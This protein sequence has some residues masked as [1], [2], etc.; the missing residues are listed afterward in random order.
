MASNVANLNQCFQG[1]IQ[2]V[3]AR[4]DLYQGLAKINQEI[5]NLAS[6]FNARQPSLQIFSHFPLLSNGLNKFFNTHPGFRQFYNSKVLDFPINSI[7]TPA[8]QLPTLILKAN[9]AVG[10]SE[11][12]YELSPSR[13]LLLGRDLQHQKDSSVLHIPLPLYKKVSG[14]HAEIQ[15]VSNVGSATQSWQL[16][17]LNS[18]NG[19]YI[20]GQKIKGCQVLTFGDRITLSYPNASEK[21]PEFVFEGQI[22]SSD[23]NA[24][25]S[26]QVDAD[27]VFLVIHP[28]QGLSVSEKQLIKQI[29]KTSV[30]GFVI[31][32]D[33]SGTKSQDSPSIK[34]NLDSIRSWIQNQY[35]QLAASLEL[36]ELSLYP[37]YPDTPSAQLTPAIEQQFVQFAA[38]FIDLAKNQG[39]ELIANRIN[40]QLLVQIQKIDQIL[41]S[42]EEALKH[43]MQRTEA[44]LNGR[45]L[46]SWR[47]HYNQ[48][49]KQIDEAR[50]DFF[51]EARTQFFRARDEFSMDFIPSSLIQKIDAFISSLEPGVTRLN[52]QVCIQFQSSNGQALH[53]AMITFCQTELTQ[54][55]NQ[56]WKK[57]RCD[58]DGDGLEGLLR[59]TY[60]QL[61]CIPE[62]QLTNAFGISST[63]IDF[64]NHFQATFSEV[65]ADISYSE[66]SGN[67]FGGIAKIAMLTATTAITAVA[68]SP[69]AIIQGA[70][71]LS[72]LGGFI[73]GSLSRSQQEKLKLEQVV[74]SLRRASS[75][76]YRNI[77]RYLINRVAQ[78]IGSTIDAEERRFRKAQD[79]NDEQMRGYFIEL[80]NISRG[81]RVRQEMHYKDR[82]AFDQIKLLGG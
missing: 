43:E 35:P 31:V 51:R 59:K 65:K 27:L 34:A 13:S 45:T 48:I 81:Y 56:Q 79:T 57:I 17:D 4:V 53:T 60:T 67:A 72:A 41:S 66:T 5:V 14:H 26:D 25:S 33:I 18:T 46:E 20:N 7:V 12:R 2:F 55:G 73:G 42:Q 1:A 62:F 68:L 8:S 50:D 44:S 22:I 9:S 6:L 54:W 40:Q 82:I 36:I 76:H 19:T 77:A 3:A 10:Q 78:E 69:Y 24:S 29:S 64:A 15:L 49:R 63:Q 28:T 52:G 71:T 70:N 16:C 61:N 58:I 37:F 75:N 47:D 39:A 74:D 30:F 38:P 32:A 11:A 23:T 21:A 80:E